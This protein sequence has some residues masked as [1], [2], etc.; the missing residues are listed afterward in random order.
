MNRELQTF[1]IEYDT[2]NQTHE[3][4]TCS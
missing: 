3:L 4:L 2:L 1:I